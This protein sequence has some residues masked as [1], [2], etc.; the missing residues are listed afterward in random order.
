MKK[1]NI[2]NKKLLIKNKNLI[3]NKKVIKEGWGDVAGDMMTGDAWSKIAMTALKG[4]YDAYRRAFNTTVTLPWKIVTGIADGKDLSDIMD[5]WERKD[6]R[7]KEEQINIIKNTG[8]S[9]TVDAFVGICNP[10]ALIFQKWCDYN[11]PELKQAWKSGSTDLW[12]RTFGEINP[13][14]KIGKKEDTRKASAKIVYSNFVINVCKAIGI[15]VKQKKKSSYEDVEASNLSLNRYLDETNSISKNNEKFKKFFSYLIVS[16]KTNSTLVNS[17]SNKTYKSFISDSTKIN[18]KINVIENQMFKEIAEKGMTISKGADILLANNIIYEIEEI[19]HYLQKVDGIKLDFE[20][21]LKNPTSIDDFK[22]KNKEGT[23]ED[24]KSSVLER[25]EIKSLVIEKKKLSKKKLIKRDKKI[26]KQA[27]KYFVDRISKFYTEHLRVLLSIKYIIIEKLVIMIYSNTYNIYSQALD[28]FEKENYSIDNYKNVFSNEF[29]LLLNLL[30]NINVYLEKNKSSSKLISDDSEMTKNL[31]KQF[32]S[33]KISES[34]TINE[35]KNNLSIQNNKIVDGMITK[36]A[37][38]VLKENAGS[39]DAEITPDQIKE[40]YDDIKEKVGSS[41]LQ[42]I[43]NILV[44]ASIAKDWDDFNKAGE[45]EKQIKEIETGFQD[46]IETQKSLQRILSSKKRKAY[47]KI[48]PSLGLRMNDL[49]KELENTNPVEDYTV[50]I[51]KIKEMNF[52]K[53]MSDLTKRAEAIIL[54]KSEDSD[55]DDRTASDS[56]GNEFINISGGESLT[57]LFVSDEK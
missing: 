29:E 25:L 2:K 9:K 8:V 14:L 55:S 39:E 6:K 35:I 24:L 12:D 45:L 44:S 1:I 47:I 46:I 36:I 32:E 4:T 3:N 51:N 42:E 49:I 10:G 5:E 37:E 50:F 21:F 13:E 53:F 40:K 15:S 18:N 38:L 43:N 11:D 54:E 48:L 57:G 31:I 23:K 34:K 30:E 27:E 56:K 17:T 52:E 26:K 7:I 20:K 33:E 16:L 28:N 41:D 19:G 22:N